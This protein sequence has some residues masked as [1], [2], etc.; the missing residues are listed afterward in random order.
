MQSIYICIFLTKYINCLF[1]LGLKD[2]KK[3]TK[4]LR[5]FLWFNLSMASIKNDTV[6]KPQPYGTAVSIS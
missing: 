4:P 2:I 3:I 6:D 1:K 5:M